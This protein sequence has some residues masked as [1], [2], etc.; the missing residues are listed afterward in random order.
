MSDA[1]KTVYAWWAREI[2]AGR[3]VTDRKLK[4]LLRQAQLINQRTTPSTWEKWLFWASYKNRPNRTWMQSIVFA[5]VLYAP[6]C[7]V[8]A[9]LF[10]DSLEMTPLHIWFTLEIDFIIFCGILGLD[11]YIQQLLDSLF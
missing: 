1:T 11:C 4:T 5:A 8:F 9:V 2:S 10:S 3:R 7:F 6:V